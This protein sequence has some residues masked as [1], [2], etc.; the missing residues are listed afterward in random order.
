MFSGVL[1]ITFAL[2]ALLL[3][4]VTQRIRTMYAQHHIKAANG[5]LPPTKLAQRDPV[6]A[7]DLFLQDFAAAN[8]KAFLESAKLRHAL[9]GLTFT[10]KTY[11]RTNFFTCDPKVIQ[12]VLSSQFQ[13]FDLGPLRSFSGAPLF[14][15]G[16]LTTDGHIWAHQR[17]VIRPAFARP[18]F[19][20]EFSIFQ[21]HVDQLIAL[22]R[23]NDGKVDLQKLFFRMVRGSIPTS[24]LS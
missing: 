10:S 20:Q 12:Q 19:I 3:R 9:N 8:N 13:N 22:I 23:K 16:I 6:L 24:L 15:N 21:R 14:G 4:N 7:L 5:C 11:F 17:R 1:W 2:L 18:V